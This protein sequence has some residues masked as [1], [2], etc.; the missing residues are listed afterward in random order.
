MGVSAG[1][2]FDP[3]NLDNS[4]NRLIILAQINEISMVWMMAADAGAFRAAVRTCES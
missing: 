1:G 2:T 3:W 4:R